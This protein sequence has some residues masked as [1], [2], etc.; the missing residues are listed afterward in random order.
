MER[1]SVECA[2][3]SVAVLQRSTRSSRCVESRSQSIWL[4]RTFC[5]SRNDVQRY[6]SSFCDSLTQNVVFFQP[7]IDS[8][9]IIEQGTV[10]VLP[11]DTIE[12]LQ[13]R[14]KTMEHQVFPLALKHL[15]TGRIELKEDNTIQWKW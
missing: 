4:H 6:L 13:E 14:V 7:E 8:G 10:P 3:I 9:A 2:S 15:A 5:R 1:C 12:T 11:T